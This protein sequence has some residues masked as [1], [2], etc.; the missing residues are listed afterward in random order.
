MRYGGGGGGSTWK[1]QPAQTP[2]APLPGGL[3]YYTSISIHST[4]DSLGMSTAARLLAPRPSSRPASLQ[5][6]VLQ[7]PVLEGEALL[8]PLAPLLIVKVDVSALEVE[9]TVQRTA[10]SVS[11]H[12]SGR[13]EKP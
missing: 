1:M 8:L 11:A 10:V 4:E 2:S 12:V 13:E 9:E 6:A 7:V 3:F 5:V